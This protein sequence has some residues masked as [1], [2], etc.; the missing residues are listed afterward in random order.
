MK[1]K[2]DESSENVKSPADRISCRSNNAIDVVTG[3]YNIIS[4]EKKFSIESHFHYSD[5]FKVEFN[6]F[7]P[8]V[9]TTGKTV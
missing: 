7:I 9:Y 8:V 3:V 1:K 5:F 2:K 6:K 4:I